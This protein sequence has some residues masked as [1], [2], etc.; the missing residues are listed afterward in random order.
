MSLPYT[1]YGLIL[2][3]LLTLSCTGGGET[4]S[5]PS[6][7]ATPGAAL[8]EELLGTW[9]TVELDIEYAT[10]QGGDTAYAELI[11]EADWGRVYGV[12]PPSTVFTPNGKLRRTHRLRDG[13]IANITNGIWRAQGD[14]LLVIE[15]NVT[16]TYFPQL[17]GDR[18]ELSGLVDQD[19]DGQRDDRYRAV[20]R[21]VSRTR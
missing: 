15:P 12:K 8:E 18:L 17:N 7:Q 4:E 13:Q 10:F 16:F 11:R 9:E 3:C 2:L 21:L 14:S 19:R 6:A 1:R 20:F 5:E